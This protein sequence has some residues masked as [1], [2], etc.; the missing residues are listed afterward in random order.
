LETAIFERK[1]NSSL[2]YDR[3]RQK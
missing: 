1:R 2:D 3:G